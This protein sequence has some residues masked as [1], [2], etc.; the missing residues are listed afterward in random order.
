MFHSRVRVRWRI[1]FGA[2]GTRC[3]FDAGEDAGELRKC[4]APSHRGTRVLSHGCQRELCQ[5]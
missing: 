4:A 5:N 2:I 3:V 1:T